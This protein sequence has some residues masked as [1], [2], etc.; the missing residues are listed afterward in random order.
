MHF[1]IVGEITDI[2]IIAVGSAI[3]ILPVLRK[4][5]GKGRWRKLKGIATVLLPDG[6][7]RIAEV[8]WFEAHGIGKRKMRIKRFLD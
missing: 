1:E 2:E 7:I 4:R 5:Y 6:Q 8:H 3:R